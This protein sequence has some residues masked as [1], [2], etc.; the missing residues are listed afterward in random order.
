MRVHEISSKL[1]V[2]KLHFLGNEALNGKI[3]FYIFYLF[4]YVE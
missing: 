4:S 1:N 2:W 3:L